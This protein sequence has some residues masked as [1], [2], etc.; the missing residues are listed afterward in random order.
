MKIRGEKD[1]KKYQTELSEMK[2][3]GLNNRIHKANVAERRK[4]QNLQLMGKM[5]EPEKV[6]PSWVPPQ[7]TGMATHSSNLS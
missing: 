3:V 2:N 7:R 1:L 4:D 6:H 5:V